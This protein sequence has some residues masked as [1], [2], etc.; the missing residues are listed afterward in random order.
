[1][2]ET[3]KNDPE[4]NSRRKITKMKMAVIVIG[5]GFG[6]L[7]A[8]LLFALAPSPYRYLSVVVLIYVLLRYGTGESPVDALFATV[9][10]TLVLIAGVHALREARDKSLESRRRR[11]QSAAPSGL[12]ASTSVISHTDCLGK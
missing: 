9:I 8:G 11:E 2:I 5:A 10:V 4:P 7:G 6:L 3:S 1:M 12:P